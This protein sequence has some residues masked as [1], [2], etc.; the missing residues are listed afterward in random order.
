MWP[1]MAEGQGD[2]GD[3]SPHCCSTVIRNSK[4][5]CLPHGVTYKFPDSFH[6]L[7]LLIPTFLP[8][9]QATHPPIFLTTY[10]SSCLT[11]MT[12]STFVFP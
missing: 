12:L 3:N 8:P 11:S 7:S 10:I 2:D 4:A 5:A 6:P 9:P 1:T